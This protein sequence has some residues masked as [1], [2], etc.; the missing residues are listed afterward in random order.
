MARDGDAE[1]FIGD[2]KSDEDAMPD[3]GAGTEFLADDTAHE[4]VAGVGHQRDQD[5]FKVWGIGCDDR[6]ACVFAG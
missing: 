2:V 5:D 4:H 3:G 1:D 6:E